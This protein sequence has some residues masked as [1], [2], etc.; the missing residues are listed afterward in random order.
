MTRTPWIAVAAMF[1]LNGALFGIWASRIPAVATAHAL[2]PGALGL[3]LLLLAT[4][5]IVAF[6]LAGRMADQIGAARA[7]RAVAIAYAISLPLIAFAPNVWLVALA[8][9]AFGA[10]HGGMDV[11][12]NAW[13]AE[14]ERREG[15]SFM[16][17][18]HAMFSLGAGLGAASGWAA[19]E[20]GADLS[21]HFL[22]G[23]FVVFVPTF[24]AAGAPWLKAAPAARGPLI[25]LPKGPLL[26]VGIVAF[27]SSLGEGAMADW[28][29]VFL[30]LVG[31][32]G[33]GEA[34][35]GYAVFSVAMVVVRLIGD[36]IVEA[37]GPVIAARIA[38]VAATTGVLLAVMG[39]SYETT[40]TGFAFMGVGY[41]VIMPLAF[42]RAANE[43]GLGPGAGI[44]AVATL[45]YGGL[46]LGPPII[47]FLAEALGLRTAF[48]LLAALAAL[49]ALL[50]GALRR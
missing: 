27:A 48:L 17:S 9:F 4:G 19:V 44:A 33:E 49:I 2:S 18:L 26:L 1:T 24:W 6:P 21:A 41:A 38:G 43:P 13:G 3:L 50:A 36:R 40:L 11:A 45:G 39:G 31:G 15:R 5:A 30:T 29:A 28:S 34:A 8:L 16:S 7:T 20:V 25:S 23:A 35:L 37:L 10:C 42:S 32:V 12:M 47:G 46:L 22:L 14:A